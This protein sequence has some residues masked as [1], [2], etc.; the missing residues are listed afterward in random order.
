[1]QKR[2]IFSMTC[3]SL[4]VSG[5]AAAVFALACAVLSA[6]AAEAQQLW[7]KTISLTAAEAAA[8]APP[9]GDKASFEAQ[10][11]QEVLSASNAARA[12]QGLGALS[13]DPAL[14]AIAAAYSRKM[15]AERFFNHN[16]PDGTTLKSRLGG[17]MQRLGRAAENL[18]TA[19]GKIDWRPSGVSR[20]T[21]DSWLD[22]P[23]H[24]TNLLDRDFVAAGVGVAQSGET[25]YVTMLYGAAGAGAPAGSSLVASAPSPTAPAG[26]A[27]SFETTAVGAINAARARNGLSPL[28]ADPTLAGFA[29]TR[30]QEMSRGGGLNADGGLLGRVGASTGARRVAATVWRGDNVNWSADELART[31]M[32]SWARDSNNMQA[33]MDG[34]YAHVGVGVD[35]VAGGVRLAAVFADRTSGGGGYAP[36]PQ[37]ALPQAA[38]S[39][40]SAP[41][42]DAAPILFAG[43]SYGAP[44]MQTGSIRPM[45]APTRQIVSGPVYEPG[46]FGAP[47]FAAAP[48]YNPAPVQLAA[49]P[50]YAAPVAAPVYV[51]Q[52]PLTS[53]APRPSPVYDPVYAAAPIHAPAPVYAAPIYNPAGST[54]TVTERRIEAPAGGSG[55]SV[56]SVTTTTTVASTGGVSNGGIRFLN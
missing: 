37:A 13:R 40:A 35:V 54:T 26:F 18:W 2:V 52:A 4:G 32:D 49:A 22:S 9:P 51:A 16:S 11:A 50:V 3:G 39:Y 7:A 24:R 48:V 43:V 12:Q 5:G 14:D 53:P 44:E 55:W 10:M 46:D 34:T 20:Q 38:P 42:Y 15:M 19:S 36:Q 31:M 8:Y 41:V 1:M 30:S 6:P 23:G 28:R 25:I 47:A 33:L 29:R 21:V 45:A 56:R 27:A 17:H